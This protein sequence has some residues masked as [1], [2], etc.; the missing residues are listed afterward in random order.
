MHLHIFCDKAILMLVFGSR[1]YVDGKIDVSFNRIT[2]FN[3]K[4]INDV[5]GKYLCAVTL[6][7]EWQVVMSVR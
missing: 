3:L 7:F 2:P 6:K 1:V 5:V 4:N